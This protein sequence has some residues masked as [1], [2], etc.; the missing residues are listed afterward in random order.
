MALVCFFKVE[1]EVG[2]DDGLPINFVGEGEPHIEGEPGDLQF[3]I[4]V[5]K[6]KIFERRGM[7][8]YTN[9]TISLQQALN[10][11]QMEITHLDGH[12][13]EIVRD[14]I[15]WPG[16]RIRK[17]DEGMPSISDNN[18]KGILVDGGRKT[19]GHHLA[20]TKRFSTKNLQWTSRLLKLQFYLSV[21]SKNDAGNFDGLFQ[22]F[23][24]KILA[25]VKFDIISD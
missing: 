25:V 15:T 9:V 6:H 20:Q 4:K 19:S 3:V 23:W 24:L 21:I 14:K 13:V 2:A 12:K 17:K 16:A 18:K 1:I 5:E 22:F 7:D 10:G 11:F 8:L